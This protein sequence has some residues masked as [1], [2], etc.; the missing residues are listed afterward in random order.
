[1]A[2]RLMLADRPGL[3]AQMKVLFTRVVNLALPT[4]KRAR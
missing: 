2:D 4:G 3:V 1:M